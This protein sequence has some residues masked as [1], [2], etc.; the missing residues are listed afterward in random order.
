MRRTI[1]RQR[2][3]CHTAYR[4]FIALI[5]PEQQYVCFVFE[6]EWPNARWYVQESNALGWKTITTFSS[7]C[8]LHFSQSWISG[9]Q[10]TTQIFDYMKWWSIIIH[11]QVA[12]VLAHIV[13]LNKW[14]KWKL[15]SW[16]KKK[17]LICRKS[18]PGGQEKFW[19]TPMNLSALSLSL[20]KIVFTHK[21]TEK[22]L[23]NFISA[24]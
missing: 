1:I 13:L 5:Y 7:V 15:T 9:K 12:R 14:I 21:L 19:M 23:L 18:W 22:L 6:S 17:R 3:P 2:T 8:F 10:C 11:C 4:F 24:G 20:C 16:F